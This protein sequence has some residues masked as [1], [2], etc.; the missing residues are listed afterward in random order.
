[1]RG[2]ARGLP[3]SE[4]PGEDSSLAHALTLLNRPFLSSERR[5][6]LQMLG[7]VWTS[8]MEGGWRRDGKQGG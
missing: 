2:A 7:Q 6:G 1:M 4:C 8:S 3:G 5:R